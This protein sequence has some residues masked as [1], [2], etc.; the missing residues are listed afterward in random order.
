MNEQLLVL[1]EQHATTILDLGYKV[2]LALTIAIASV[3]IARLTRRSI[4][5]GNE[6]VQRIDVMLLPLISA[7]AGYLVYTIGFIIIL[8]IFG[9]NTNSIIA[10][11]GAAGLAIGLAL[12]DTLSNIAAGIMLLFIRPFKLDDFITC[13]DIS[14]S[15][16]AMGVFVTVIE[17]ADGLYISVPNN[18]IWGQSIKNFTRNG[19]RR[20]ELTVGIDYKDSIEV[21][22]NVL[23]KLAQ[24]ETRLL[25]E[26]VPEVMVHSMADS[27][28]NLQLRVWASVDNYWGIYWSMNKRVKE[29]IE[30]AGL[31]IPFPQR[32]L[33]IMDKPAATRT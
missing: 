10:L 22:L 33:H 21:G 2:F 11:L 31:S 14:G 18:A 4:V 16:R 8:D 24:E 3:T 7:M 9:V 19:K 27:S 1:W 20:M 17:T 12:K 29:E 5:R 30:L 26:P 23:L 13:G 32:T 15:V 6:K 28:V 25:S